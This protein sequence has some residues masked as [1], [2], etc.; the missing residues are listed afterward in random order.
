MHDL[1]KAITSTSISCCSCELICLSN[2]KLV[3]EC[4]FFSILSLLVYQRFIMS[5]ASPAEEW[6]KTLLPTC[7]NDTRLTYLARLSVVTHNCLCFFLGTLL[8]CL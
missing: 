4:I 3:F 5:P 7:A 1:L 8:N 2:M 6:D